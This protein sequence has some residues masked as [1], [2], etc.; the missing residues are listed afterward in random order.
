MSFLD[1]LAG[2]A[3]GIGDIVSGIGGLFGGN[4]VGGQL[5]KTAL[6]GYALYKTQQSINKDNQKPETTT[7]PKPDPGVRLQVNPD[8][9]HKIPVLYGTAFTGGIITDAVLTNSNKTMWYCVTICEYTGYKLSDSQPSEFTFNDIYWN[10]QRLVFNSDGITVNY[11]VD[12][13][14]NNDNSLNGQVKIYCY[15]G[16]SGDLDHCVPT[17]YTLGTAY[18]AFDLMPDWTTDH[19]MN[20]LIFALVRVDYNKEKNVTNIGKLNFKLTNSMSMPGDVLYDYM[21]D[22]QYGC[23]IDPKEIYS[24]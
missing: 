4:S 19:T 1:D 13:D 18:N 6:T 9:E 5:A 3:S 17:G 8:P 22:T 11:S 7:T 2:V 12:R 10:D 20:N 16:S 21:T 15:R 14:G 23:G 24:A